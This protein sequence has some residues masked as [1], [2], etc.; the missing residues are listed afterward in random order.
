[1]SHAL[2]APA[3]GVRRTALVLSGIAV[4]FSFG[5]G[6]FL[7]KWI[8]TGDLLGNDIGL[9]W[10]LIALVLLLVAMLLR[11]AAAM[12]ELLW[13]ERTWSNLPIRSRRVGPIDNVTAVHIFGIAFIPVVAWFWKL[14]LV[15]TVSKGLEEVRRERPFTAPIPRRLGMTAVI[16]GWFPGL[17]IYLA[18]FLW[19]M[20]ARRID[21]VYLELLARDQSPSF[22]VG[23]T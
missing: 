20:F 23:S 18:P 21:V 1:V 15:V 13:L 9:L 14:G 16:L 19:E 11:I 6:I 17:N 2:K 5:F 22:T 8:A 10:L 12:C 3:R 4:L 7:R